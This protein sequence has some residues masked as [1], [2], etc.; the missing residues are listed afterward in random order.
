[1]TERTAPDQMK[2]YENSYKRMWEAI[3]HADR[4]RDEA[5]KIVDVARDLVIALEHDF[6]AGTTIASIQT[7]DAFNKLRSRLRDL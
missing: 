6:G 1:M 2:N 3:A 4:R 7:H 5:L